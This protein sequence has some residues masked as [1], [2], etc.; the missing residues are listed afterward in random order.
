MT[1]G[2]TITAVLT[3]T[4]TITGT[5]TSA[6]TTT[7]TLTTTSSAAASPSPGCGS[8]YVSNSEDT[9]YLYY[10]SINVIA[11]VNDPINYAGTL[12]YPGTLSQ[13]DAALACATDNDNG[14]GGESLNLYYRIST[15]MWDC[16]LFYDENDGDFYITDP[17]VFGSYGYTN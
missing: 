16:A 1:T 6:T 17:D 15:G 3:T 9:Y 8:V 14:H 11:D 10:S 4:N 7:T 2:T 5:T 13:C 12:Y